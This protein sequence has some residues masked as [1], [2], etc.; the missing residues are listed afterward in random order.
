[1]VE[2]QGRFDM[3][4]LYDSTKDVSVV[5]GLRAARLLDAGSEKYV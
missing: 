4:F 5:H 3:G 1:M 2:N